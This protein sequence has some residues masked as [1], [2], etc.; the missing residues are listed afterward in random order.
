M[1]FSNGVSSQ[2]FGPA[3]IKLESALKNPNQFREAVLFESLN[4]LPAAK[5]KEFLTS[6]E[7]KAMLEEGLVTRDM[8]ERLAAESDNGILKT[9]ICH[10]AKEN[11]DPAWDELVKLRLQERRLMNEL[12]EKYGEKAQPIASN[13]DKDFVEACIPEY[14]RTK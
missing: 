6:P 1:I 11:G 4:N 7:A 10:M 13:A 5:K 9:T 14:F 2:V 12:I 8:L 3:D